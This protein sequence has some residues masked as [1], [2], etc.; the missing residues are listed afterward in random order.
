MQNKSC[1]IEK[2]EK[3]NRKWIQIDIHKLNNKKRIHINFSL[4]SH[5]IY[6]NYL[7]FYKH[8]NIQIHDATKNIN[9]YLI[10]FNKKII[11]AR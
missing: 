8:T 7:Y 10:E 2:T 3:K 1:T 11:I 5:N 6:F 4:C 9:L